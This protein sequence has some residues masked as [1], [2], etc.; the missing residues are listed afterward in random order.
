MNYREKYAIAIMLLCILAGSLL[1][2]NDAG[3]AFVIVVFIVG[4]SIFVYTPKG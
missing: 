1:S 3:R 2:F 4:L